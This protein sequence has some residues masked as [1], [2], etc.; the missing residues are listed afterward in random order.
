MVSTGTVNNTVR[1]P[2]CKLKLRTGLFKQ[3]Q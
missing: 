2:T 3:T 1:V